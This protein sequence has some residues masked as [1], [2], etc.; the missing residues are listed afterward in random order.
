MKRHPPMHPSSLYPSPLPSLP[1][2]SFSQ[3]AAELSCDSVI[4]PPTPHTR[5]PYT[6]THM[7][8]HFFFPSHTCTSTILR[9][10][11]F[12]ACLD[13]FIIRNAVGCS[14][15]GGLSFVGGNPLLIAA[16]Q[17]MSSFSQWGKIIHAG[18][19]EQRQ[20][21]GRPCV[22]IVSALLTTL[23]NGLV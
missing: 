13:T 14:R 11:A 19:W 22:N 15:G 8:T 1:A 4:S 16:D 21:H 6:N 3:T 9:P 17:S 23:S 5:A 20:A 18:T 10:V 12:I 2:S 7:Y